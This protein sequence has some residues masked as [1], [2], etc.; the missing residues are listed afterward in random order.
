MIT[1]NNEAYEGLYPK[2]NLIKLAPKDDILFFD[3]ETTGLSRKN[4]HIYLIGCGRYSEN[5]L[6]IIQW[7]AENEMDEVNVLKAFLD[8]SSSFTYLVNYNGKSFDIPFVTERLSKYGLS[9]PE[10]NSIDLYTYVK[11]LKNILSL[12]DIT[13]KSVENYLGITRKDKYNGKELI[14]VYKK[15]LLSGNGLNLLLLHNKEDVLNMH[16]VVSILDYVELFN[17]HIKYKNYGI[18]KYADFNGDEQIELILNGLHNFDNLPKS[19]NTFKNTGNGSYIMNI[20]CDKTVKIRV[21]LFSDTLYFYFDNYKDYYYLP[22]EDICI[23]KTMAGG[24]KK[25]NRICATKDNCRVKIND[26]FIELPCSFNKSD[27]F[28]RT[29]KECYKSK[30]VFIRLADF[31]SLSDDYK[32]EILNELYK[33]FL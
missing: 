23:L 14:N 4:N 30:R 5:K 13:Q 18:N 10:F 25:E 7:F 22:N 1:I 20:S 31:E 21:P 26:T 9:M 24:V 15:Y 6:E 32:T 16:N 12:C 27:M 11:P 17:T 29:F 3:I 28:I 2:D 33:E 19:I 8:Y